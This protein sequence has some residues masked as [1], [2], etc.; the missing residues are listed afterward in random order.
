[1]SVGLECGE[2]EDPFVHAEFAKDLGNCYFAK[3][4]GHFNV[5][6]RVDLGSDRRVVQSTCPSLHQYVSVKLII[7]MLY[8]SKLITLWS[9]YYKCVVSKAY[10]V[11]HILQESLTRSI[12][13]QMY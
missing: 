6:L 11:E 5:A 7:Y 1:M 13:Y 2:W 9:G 3:D 12:T 8:I 10:Y 4:Q